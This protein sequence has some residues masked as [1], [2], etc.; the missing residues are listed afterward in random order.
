MH[1]AVLVPGRWHSWP[2]VGL[3]DPSQFWAAD[4]VHAPPAGV[5]IDGS[6]IDIRQ[7]PESGQADVLAS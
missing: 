7:V 3:R 4:R 6:H 5:A 1:G 2:T